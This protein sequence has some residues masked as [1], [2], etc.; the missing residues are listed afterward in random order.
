MCQVE[1]SA[2]RAIRTR[3]S[4][5]SIFWLTSS[6]GFYVVGR[7]D[8]YKRQ[9]YGSNDGETFEPIDTQTNVEFSGRKQSKVFSL[10]KSVSYQYIKFEVTS[11]K[12]GN[13]TD[14]VQLSELSFDLK[15]STGPSYTN[16][17][18]TLDLDN[19][20]AKV[21]YLSLIHI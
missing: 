18:R 7:V 21:E 13:T 11:N 10:G 8:V 20:T 12:S 5:H 6:L 15:S 16:Y 4:S 19:A 9:L 1:C 3:V 17:K 2:C 14:G